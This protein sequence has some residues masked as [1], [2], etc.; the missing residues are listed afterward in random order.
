MAGRITAR[1][2]VKLT[3]EI[4]VSDTWGQDCAFLQ[5][6]QQALSAA[7]GRIQHGGMRD[8]VDYTVIGKPEVTAILLKEEDR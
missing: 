6:Q 2:R 5:V 4:P 8:G 7:L 1:A 3:I